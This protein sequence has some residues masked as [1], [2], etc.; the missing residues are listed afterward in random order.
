MRLPFNGQFRLTQGWGENPEVYKR[1]NLKGHNGQDYGL[2]NGT[3]VVDPHDGKILERAFDKDGYG[4]YLKIESTIEGSI[5]AHLKEFKVNL[6]DEVKEGQLVAISDNTGFS[7][8]PHLHW[9]YYRIPRNRTDGYLGY[10]DQTTYIDTTQK[11]IDQLREE[12]DKNWRLYQEALGKEAQYQKQ[13]SDLQ[14]A[15]N[16][17]TEKVR[18]LNEAMAKDARDDYE[19]AIELTKIQARFAD[20]EEEADAIAY[21]VSVAPYKFQAVLDGIN[22]LKIPVENAVKPVLQQ[23]NE[24]FDIVFKEGL[25]LFKRF[26][27]PQGFFAKIFSW[28]RR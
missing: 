19:I 23:R 2:P 24:L 25:A 16:T 4:N 22:K 26:R 12:R 11:T 15:T 14:N 28:F 3:E 18:F 5:L 20:L 17:F 13:I 27:P 21:A 8:G 10:I 1:F 7:T 6:N 9:G